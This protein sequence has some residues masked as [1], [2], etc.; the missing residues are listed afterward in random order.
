[1]KTNRGNEGGEW[2]GGTEGASSVG[3]T[4]TRGGTMMMMMMMH[5]HDHDVD[6]DDDDDDHDDDH[7]NDGDEDEERQGLTMPDL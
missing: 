6:D 2:T 3:E 7:D 5:N 4:S 1:M